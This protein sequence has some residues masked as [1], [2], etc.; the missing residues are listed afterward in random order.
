[1]VTL[2]WNKEFEIMCDAS[3][4]AMGAVL[5]KEL[6]SCSRPYTMPKKPSMRLKRI[7]PQLKKRCWQWC[8]LVKNSGLTY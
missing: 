5:D 8:L 7:T 3:D 4:F 2:D 6:R 1:M